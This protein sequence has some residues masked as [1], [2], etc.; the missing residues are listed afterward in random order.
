[1][2]YIPS[3]FLNATLILAPV[4][5]GY[6]VINNDRIERHMQEAFLNLITTITETTEH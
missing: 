2:E 1:M 6:D 5:P 3:I 4:Q